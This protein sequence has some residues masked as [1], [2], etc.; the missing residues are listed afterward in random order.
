MQ[1]QQPDYLSWIMGS[2][3]STEVKGIAKDALQGVFP[4]KK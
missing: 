3:F 2:D 1:T 4:E